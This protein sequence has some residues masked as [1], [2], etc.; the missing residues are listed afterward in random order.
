MKFTEILIICFGINC[1]LPLTYSYDLNC[2]TDEKIIVCYFASWAIYR[3]AEGS[4]KVENI[5]P[6]LCTHIVYTFAGL[7][8]H[9]HIVSLDIEND[10][11]RHRE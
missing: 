9:G 1:V 6:F 8:I 4:F 3:P 2:P 11:S 5:D 10:V 7:D